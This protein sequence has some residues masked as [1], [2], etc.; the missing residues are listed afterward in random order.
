MH[1]KTYAR[2]KSRVIFHRA[3]RRAPWLRTFGTIVLMGPMFDKPVVLKGG[4][5]IVIQESDEDGELRTAFIWFKP[6]FHRWAR[7]LLILGSTFVLGAAVMRNYYE[8]F[9]MR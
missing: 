3:G 4:A 9:V 8:F 1:Q 5:T 7:K 2:R 6:R